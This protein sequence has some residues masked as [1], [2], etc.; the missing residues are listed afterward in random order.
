MMPPDT[1]T[2]KRFRSCNNAQNGGLAL[3]IRTNQCNF[4]SSFYFCF[5]MLNDHVIA[6]TFSQIF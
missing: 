2:C 5:C 3:S 4:I 6:E 1:F